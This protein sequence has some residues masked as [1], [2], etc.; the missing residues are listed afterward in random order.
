M[1][2]L[3][4]L[5]LILALPPAQEPTEL[6]NDPT[7]DFK[8]TQTALRHDPETKKDVEEITL[9][10]EGDKAIPIKVEK[11]KEIIDLLG[12][13]ARYFTEP[14]RGKMSKEILVTAK[15]GTLNNEARFLKLDDDVR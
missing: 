2:A 7:S 1:K 8:I 6:P 4:L 5:V 14:D 3:G 10:L 15:R 12:V 11:N 13:R 9:I